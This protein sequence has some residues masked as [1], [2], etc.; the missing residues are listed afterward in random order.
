MCAQQLGLNGLHDPLEAAAGAW[1]RW[2]VG[3]AGAGLAR[4]PAPGSPALGLC[5]QLT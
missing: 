1:G 5:Q 2:G 3:E 4:S